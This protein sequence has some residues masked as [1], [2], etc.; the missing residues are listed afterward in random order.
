MEEKCFKE[1]VDGKNSKFEADWFRC[2]HW[3]AVRTFSDHIS[4]ISPFEAL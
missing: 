1:L 2:L 4:I 3:C